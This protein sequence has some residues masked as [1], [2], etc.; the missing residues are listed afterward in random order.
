MSF[1]PQYLSIKSYV[2][3]NFQHFIAGQITSVDDD[4]KFC[5]ATASRLAR[6]DT[7][8]LSPLSTTHESPDTLGKTGESACRIGFCRDGLI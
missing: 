2:H 6:S 1:H 5:L 4:K 8:P 3:M 7:T